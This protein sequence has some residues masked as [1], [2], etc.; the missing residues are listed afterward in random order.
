MALHYRLLIC[1]VVASPLS[2]LYN[3]CSVTGS[4][5]YLFDLHAAIAFTLTAILC[6]I[7][8]GLN[9]GSAGNAKPRK[10]RASKNGQQQGEVKWFNGGKGFGFIT[11]ENGD[12]IFVH[13][14]SVQKDSARLSPGKRVEFT[15][16]QG[17]KGAEAENVR[18]LS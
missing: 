16:G 11:C 15:I 14:R 1:I 12:E 13:F 2:A 3:G 5:S 10:P 18:V 7:L 17:Q 4:L 9:L 8:S 6:V